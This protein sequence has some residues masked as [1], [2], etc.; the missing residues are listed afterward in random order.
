MGCD[1]LKAQKKRP[2]LSQ[3]T[4]T[5]EGGTK[6]SRGVSAEFRSSTDCSLT[7]PKKEEAAQTVAMDQTGE[8]SLLKV[9]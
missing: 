1:Y 5:E 4:G 8:R 3:K 9:L 6:P 7:E 2:W